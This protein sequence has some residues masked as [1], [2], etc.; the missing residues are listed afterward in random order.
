MLRCV[1]LLGIAGFC[2]IAWLCSERRGL[3]PWRT[4]LVGVALQL[5]IGA[6]VF[7]APG[8][9]QLFLWAN[10][11]IAALIEVANAGTAYVFGGLATG[12][13]GFP[14]G[15]Q[16]P[17]GVILAFQ[18]F[19]IAI[20]FSA[21]TAAAYRLGLIQPVVRLF[22][23]LFHRALRISGAEAL[24]TA[25][26][27]VVGVESALVVR[28]YLLRMTRSELLV[29][30]TAGMATVAST[31]LGLYMQLLHDVFPT[32]GGHLISATLIAIP[33][34]IVIAKL[35]IPE[36]GAPETLGAIPPIA[37]ERADGGVMAALLGGALDGV[38]L[39]VGIAAGL[40]ALLGVVALV[41]KGLGRAGGWVHLPG[42]SLTGI[43]SQ[44]AWP[45]AWLLGLRGEDVAPAAGL[46]GQRLV[47]TEFPA[48]IHLAALARDGV[49]DQRTL[50][51][52]S[53]ALCGFAH[54]ASMAVFVGGTAALVPERRA[55]LAGLGFKALLAAT[56]ATLM[57]GAVAGVFA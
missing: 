21:I 4:V 57:T 12:S 50:V 1:S 51:V 10:D 31:V 48:F 43:L 34:S 33:A 25:A 52:M 8:S 38:K 24:T 3:V 35:I 29:L 9:R 55:D 56:L 40:I 18:V 17:T 28:P 32:I 30:L 41:D 22:A 19:P 44:A 36:D 47:Q 54:L 5:A 39:A 53:Y 16:Q 20:F 49:I 42:L 6:L 13:L 27:I 11:G 14:G 15:P 37:V 7:L 26:N 2:A 45:L 23:R 46:I